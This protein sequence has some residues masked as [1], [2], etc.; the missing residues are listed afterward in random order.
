VDLGELTEALR[1]L[2][3]GVSMPV[4]ATAT[5]SSG[6]FR[7]T[8]AGEWKR[9]QKKKTWTR[10]PVTAKTWKR[11]ERN[12]KI[13]RKREKHKPRAVNADTFRRSLERVRGKTKTQAGRPKQPAQSAIWSRERKRKTQDDR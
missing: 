11:A 12:P 3:S 9:V 10:H 7:K 8:R 4:G 13:V 5:R 1:E 2:V 6:V